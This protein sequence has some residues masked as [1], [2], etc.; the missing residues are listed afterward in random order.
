[1]PGGQPTNRKQ[2]HRPGYRHVDDRWVGK[3]VV[4]AFEILGRHPDT[5]VLNFDHCSGAGSK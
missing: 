1:M 4:D 2:T 3:P 5:A